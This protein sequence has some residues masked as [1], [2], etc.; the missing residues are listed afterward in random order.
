MPET[1]FFRDRGAFDAVA[2][3]AQGGAAP[4]RY[5]CVPCATGEE[6]LSL[7]MTLLD[8][9]VAPERFHIDAFDISERLVAHA[10]RGVY[11]RNSFRGNDAAFRSR[12]FQE[13]RE[14][15]EID[16]PCARR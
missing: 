3:E 12:Y 9:G 13:T 6:P 16:R 4:L 8:A 11:G 5:L 1:W 2:A 10:E 7:A 15:C 14:G